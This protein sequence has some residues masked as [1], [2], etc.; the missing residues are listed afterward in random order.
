M[1]EEVGL[2][3]LGRATAQGG[4][5]AEELD[6]YADIEVRAET[7]PEARS[8]MKKLR[9]RKKQLRQRKK[10][11]NLEMK[12]IR[13][14][15]RDKLSGRI[16]RGFFGAIRKA[17]KQSARAQRDRELEP[18]QAEKLK[19]DDLILQIDEAILKL[20]DF[21]EEMKLEA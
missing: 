21:I 14:R 6:L 13:A 11:I 16:G 15:Y 1:G 20:Q 18:L 3:T 9:L 7:I 19:I 12:Q 17:S 2:H 8:A 5:M 4:E 10:L